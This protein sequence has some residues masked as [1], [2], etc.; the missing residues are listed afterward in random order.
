MTSPAHEKKI[1][2]FKKKV[3]KGIQECKQCLKNQNYYI[4][5]P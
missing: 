1:E 2:K 3:F 5:L 4:L